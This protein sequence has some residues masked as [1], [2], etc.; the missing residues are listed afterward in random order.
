MSWV[1]LKQC[2]QAAAKEALGEGTKKHLK[3][4]K[5]LPHK[6][7]YDKEYKEA[8]KNLKQLTGDAYKQVEKQFHAMRQKKGT[9]M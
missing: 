3:P 4:I 1:E 6:P 5:G 8:R 7:W 9:T 2:M